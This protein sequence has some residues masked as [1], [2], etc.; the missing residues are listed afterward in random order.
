[1]IRK[2]AIRIGIIGLITVLPLIQ[3]SGSP[4]LSAIAYDVVNSPY[5]IHTSSVG[6][7]GRSPVTPQRGSNSTITVMGKIQG[8]KPRYQACTPRYSSF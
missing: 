7:A 5:G 6:S 2:N 3:G 1:M 8:S 4:P